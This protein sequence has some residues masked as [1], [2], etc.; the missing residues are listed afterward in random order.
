MVYFPERQSN[1]AWIARKIF[2][3]RIPHTVDFQ[4]DGAEFVL[5][6]DVTRFVKRQSARAAAQSDDPRARAVG[7]LMALYQRRLASSAYA[8]RRSL[9][10][11]ATRLAEGLNPA[12]P[13]GKAV[14][15]GA[16][17]G[18]GGPRLC[19][20]TRKSSKRWKRES[21]TAWSDFWRRSHWPA[22]PSRCTRRLPSCVVWR[23]RR[24]R[25]KRRVRRRG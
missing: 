5:Y 16:R 17:A 11:R 6:Q 15:G 21:V 14:C 1:G 13:G 7:F 12:P 19:C 18:G 10:N 2:T 8:V 20:P 25:W 23:S 4:I 3:Q 24:M 22:T 9:Q